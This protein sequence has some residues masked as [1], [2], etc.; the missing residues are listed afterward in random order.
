MAKSKKSDSAVISIVV[1]VYNEAGNLPA[2]FGRI[3]PVLESLKL[4]WEIICVD[5]GSKDESLDLLR[6][7]HK[8]DKRIKLIAFSRNFG[9]EIALTAGLDAAK[10]AAIIPIDADLQDPPELIPDMV[11]HWQKGEKVV[12]AVRKKRAREGL[13]RKALSKAFYHLFAKI[14][15][16]ELVPDAGD[17]R[18]LDRQVVDI[19]KSMHERTR[20]MKGLFA[21]SGYKP[22]IL[23]FERENRTGGESHFSLFKLWRLAWDGIVSFSTFPLVLWI[24]LGSFISLSAFIYAVFIT[25]RTWVLGV[26]V[27]GYASLMTVMLFLGGIQL[28]SLG[29]IGMYLNKVFKETKQ[30]PLYVIMEKL[31]D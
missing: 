23:Y 1:P 18:L 26:D 29:V 14:S 22:K 8:K 15:S 13:I 9:K 10:G 20:F 28:M 17:F 4:P 27:P 11:S 5:D 19:V 2:F 21:W 16:V 31:G 12:L 30:R 3:T 7:V 6:K 25:V 24:Y